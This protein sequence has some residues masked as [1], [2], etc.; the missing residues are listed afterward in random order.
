MS[1]LDC[2]GP[3]TICSRPESPS[4]FC[5]RCSN[6]M[7]GRQDRTFPRAVPLL[8]VR[9]TLS[10]FSADKFVHCCRCVESFSKPSSP[11]GWPA[12]IRTS[13]VALL[14]ARIAPNVNSRHDVRAEP[15]QSTTNFF[16][17]L[18][19]WR[20]ERIADSL[21]SVSTL[22]SRSV[23]MV[24]ACMSGA[25]HRTMMLMAAQSG[26]DSTWRFKTGSSSRLCRYPLTLAD[27]VTHSP[28][29]LSAKQRKNWRRWSYGFEVT[30]ELAV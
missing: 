22:G 27:G 19:S 10:K 16:I 12:N 18:Q 30:L 14:L 23:L 5:P 7:R 29:W 11:S 13:K 4:L 20:A 3:S 2:L 21:G 26:T 9:L 1:F 28:K 8:E 25:C 6:S 17:D 24:T 15:K